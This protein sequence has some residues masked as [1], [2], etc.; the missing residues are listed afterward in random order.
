MES[1]LGHMWKWKPA[2]GIS[3][4]SVPECVDT[5]DKGVFYVLYKPQ[6]YQS[7]NENNMALNNNSI[8]EALVS[9]E[10]QCAHCCLRWPECRSINVGKVEVLEHSVYP[11]KVHASIK[12][13]LNHAIAYSKPSYKYGFNYYYEFLSKDLEWREEM[14]RQLCVMFTNKLRCDSIQIFN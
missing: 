14:Q 5:K 7:R 8:R 1:M 10:I 6:H 2:A 13:Q 3:M 9:S 12:C 4:F 11:A